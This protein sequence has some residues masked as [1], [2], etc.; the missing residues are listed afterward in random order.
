MA[1]RQKAADEEKAYKIYVTD[2]LKA[3]YNLNARYV[4]FLEPQKPE[5]TRTAEEIISDISAKLEALNKE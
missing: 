2:S 3:A 5:D 4:D 1:A